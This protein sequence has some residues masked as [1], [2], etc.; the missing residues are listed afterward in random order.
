MISSLKI[1]IVADYFG[2][3]GMCLLCCWKG[4]DEQDLMEVIW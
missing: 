3:I 2:G 1:K 4:L